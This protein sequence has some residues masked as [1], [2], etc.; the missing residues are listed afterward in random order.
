MAM[1]NDQRVY[2]NGGFLLY[3]LYKKCP[4]D[5]LDRKTMV[6][7]PRELPKRNP[8]NHGLVEKCWENSKNIMCKP[9]VDHFISCSHH[10]HPFS[11]ICSNHFPSF[12]PMFLPYVP[13]FPPLKMAIAV[14]VTLTRWRLRR[15]AAQSPVAAESCRTRYS[16]LLNPGL[17]LCTLYYIWL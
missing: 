3:L 7:S 17:W 15:S 16:V 2:K 10:F 13:Y 9:L 12:S 8:Q 6:S 5:P 4:N 14:G 1:L 11:P